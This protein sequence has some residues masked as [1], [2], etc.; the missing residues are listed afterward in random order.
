MNIDFLIIKN[1]II[2]SVIFIAGNARKMPSDVRSALL[3]IIQQ[4]G[5]FS[6][7]ESDLYI[8]RM[9]QQKRY[10]VEAWS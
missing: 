8:R 3:E 7:E 9:I 2:A 6:Q 1:V 5:D 4:Y 10:I